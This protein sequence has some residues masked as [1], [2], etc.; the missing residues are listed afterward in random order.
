MSNQQNQQPSL[1]QPDT[2]K[3]P[4]PWQKSRP[5]WK[6]FHHSI[7]KKEESVEKKVFINST[8]I[9]KK[10]WFPFLLLPITILIFLRFTSEQQPALPPVIDRIPTP[11]HYS[12]TNWLIYT[13]EK[14]GFE[15]KYPRN[16]EITSIDG[17]QDF[18]PLTP[19]PKKE[20]AS[21]ILIAKLN[22]AKTNSE[23][24]LFINI[25]QNPNRITIIEY[26]KNEDV[27]Y[28][29]QNSM[30]ESVINDFE[31]VKWPTN[32]DSSMYYLA[33]DN[34]IADFQLSVFDEQKPSQ[35]SPDQLLHQILST[36]K[37]INN[38]SNWKTYI[39]NEYGYEVKHPN[40]SP[41]K[42]HT[43]NDIYLNNVTFGTPFSETVWF[44]LIVREE[45]LEKAVEFDKWQASHSVVKLIEE[46]E[47][48]IDGQP[49]VLLTYET[50]MEEPQ[51]STT[52]AIIYKKPYAYT[53]SSRAIDINQILS[54]FEF[55]E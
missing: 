40:E 55:T 45:S 51:R 8:T 31:V 12:T 38:T 17:S 39:N 53:I 3:E 46:R 52:F 5:S 23:I 50:Q 28:F 37:F 18:P 10:L 15:I 21:T 6:D 7:I 34:Y 2:I 42:E 19:T 29:Y 43:D 9:L 4:A 49:A 44:S 54:T 11:S 27:S 48:T 14:Y 32:P 41:P 22:P 20:V 1:N 30:Q 24:Q 25:I 36:F 35:L 13:N 33:F 47:S 16:W 26:L